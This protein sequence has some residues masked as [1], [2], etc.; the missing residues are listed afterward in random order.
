MTAQLFGDDIVK[1]VKDMKQEASIIEDSNKNRWQPIYFIVEIGKKTSGLTKRPGR[2]KASIC[3]I[4]SGH[5]RKGVKLFFLN[6][7]KCGNHFF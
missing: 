3:S 5:P 6:C 1:T 4:W 7:G 2:A